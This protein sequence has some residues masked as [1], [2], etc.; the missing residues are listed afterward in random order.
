M[1]EL[2]C[3]GQSLDKN[4][5]DWSAQIGL[6]EKGSQSEEEIKERF[7]NPHLSQNEADL[8]AV[9]L[10]KRGYIMG[11]YEIMD[12]WAERRSNKKVPESADV[13]QYISYL[14][15]RSDDPGIIHTARGF[16][17][18]VDIDAVHYR[19]TGG[20]LL[21]KFFWEFNRWVRKETLAQY[22]WSEETFKEPQIRQEISY[23]NSLLRPKGLH[24]LNSRF[25][26]EG[27]RDGVSRDGFYKLTEDH[28]DHLRKVA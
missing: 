11:M 10:N 8:W 18:G 16:G 24:I 7:G 4:F 28:Q 23:L 12:H 17:Y 22:L 15:K 27:Y 13:K 14:R 25:A 19:Y 20:Y 3:A 2:Y 21:Q 9:L 5:Q 1:I 26:T 6:I